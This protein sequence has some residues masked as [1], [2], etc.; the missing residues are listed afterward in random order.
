MK[1]KALRLCSMVLIL[2]MLLSITGCGGKTVAE[3]DK[4]HVYKYEDIDLPIELDDIRGA[5]YHDGRVYVIGTK[6]EE[7]T[8][9][10]LCSVN[11]DGSDGKSVKLKT[12]YE[13]ATSEDGET[14][15]AEPAE[16]SEITEDTEITEDIMPGDM[17]R[18]EV[19]V[20]EVID[21]NAEV[22]TEDVTDDSLVTEHGIMEEFVAPQEYVYSWLNQVT[23]DE[24]ANFYGAYEIYR[25]YT[26]ENG[27][28][29]SESNYVLVCWNS[30]GELQWNADVKEGVPE[31]DYFYINS[32]LV[33][34]EGTVWVNGGM[35]IKTYDSQGNQLNMTKFPEDTSG[36]FFMEKD[37]TVFVRTWNPEYTKQF[38]QVIDK[39]TLSFGAKE[40]FPENIYAYGIQ[41]EGTLY[42]FVLTD[43]T[44]VYGYNMG[45]EQP[46]EIMDTVD[47][48][49]YSG[50]LNSIQ[51]I[52]DTQLMATYYDPTDWRNSV[53]IFT[54]VPPEEV[55]DKTAIVM[56][57][58]YLDYDMRKRV[59]DFNK[60]N[61]TYRIQIR[62][63]SNYST[64]EDY[65]AGYTKL[66]TDIITGNMPDILIVDS[67]M[68]IDSYIAKGLIADLNPLFDN[69]PELKREDYLEN[70]FEAFSQDG[71]MYQL[72]P[73]FNVSTIIGKTSIVG[74]RAG[75]NMAEYKEV[76][77]AQSEDAKSFIETTKDGMMYTALTMTNDEYIDAETGKCY[78]NSPGFVEL[79]E[80]V[81]QF[82]TEI[83]YSVWEND[84]YWMQIENAY[85]E[86]RAIL[87]NRYISNYW[88][89][90]R[91]EKGQ[92]G[93][94]VTIIG[95]PTESRNGN[96]IIPNSQIAL[97]A[98]SGCQEGAWEFIRYYLTDEYQEGLD[99][100]F[101]VK[102][103]ALAKLEQEA[104]ERPYWEYDDGTK[105]YYDET[106]WIY[107]KE[108]IID[109]MT[110]EEAT[111]FTEFLSSLTLV[112][113][114]D[115][116]VSEII[117]E[118]AQ[119]F[120]EGQKTA[121]QVADIIQSRVQLYI[122]ENR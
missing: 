120:F 94:E 119:A 53:A 76:M 50:G 23:M 39:R 56:A 78:F 109:P 31:E 63:Y 51:L 97:S 112:G 115:Q 11:V 28:Y 91:I 46:V 103:S 101:P 2:S 95:F 114:Y 79:L 32:M 41:Q 1:K 121:Q 5:Y 66:N 65:L 118:E 33:D 64:A 107:D 19:A 47:S 100:Q 45:D 98:R 12:G 70:I 57:S 81:N 82:P 34:K 14:E 84:D 54:K 58:M 92:F 9:T 87:L 71:K 122:S 15:S 25:D 88:D 83:D 72:V 89:F 36:T 22:D 111:E 52:S 29:I 26:N 4:D 44:S 67:Q 113:S 68:P 30:E 49:L 108:V 105:E 20:E 59:V 3:M 24:K 85:R 77:A 96:A 60:T 6:Y 104:M 43:S 73:A 18:T 8:N 35:Y 110:K 90:N 17:A 48:D 106:Y 80:F 75:W 116:S 55:K 102:K 10:Y 40:E 62:E 93:E 61:D 16:D 13:V 69:D 37:G 21:E 99:Y 86:N 38:K 42:D 117:N 7:E 74:D 27:E